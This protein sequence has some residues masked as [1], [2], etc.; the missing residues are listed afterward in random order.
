MRQQSAPRRADGEGMASRPP[1][2]RAGRAALGAALAILLG[3][4]SGCLLMTP[5]GQ[6][7]VVERTTQDDI[8]DGNGMLVERTS[9]GRMCKVKVRDSLGLVVARWF[10]CEHVHRRMN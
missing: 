10:E 5:H 8:W 1:R 9:D 7:V 6:P 3:P 2:R 4:G